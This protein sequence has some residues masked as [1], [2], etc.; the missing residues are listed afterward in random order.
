M[1]RAALLP[2]PDDGHLALSV[3]VRLLK[4]YGLLLREVRR[5]VPEDLTLPQFDV[6]AQ[7]YRREDGMTPGE[8]TRALLVTAGNVTGIV[9]RLARLGL[10]ERRPVPQDRRAVRVRL[11]QRG[12]QLMQRAIP[13]HRRDVESAMAGVPP[14]LLARLR[15]VLGSLNRAL[16]ER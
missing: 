14:A 12:R 2:E 8:L 11:T 5:F 15:D 3:W 9:D 16:E 4:S 1:S 13:R 7:L 6:L 10:A